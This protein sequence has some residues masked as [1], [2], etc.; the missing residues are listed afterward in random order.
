[1]VLFENVHIAN[2]RSETKSAFAMSIFRSPILIYG[3]IGAFLIH[4]LSMYLPLGQKFLRTEP[5]DL[6]T[7]MLALGCSLSILV[8]MEVHKLFWKCRYPQN[9]N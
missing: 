1:M 4:V 2:C 9:R 8:I 7:W 5:V 6:S 3:V